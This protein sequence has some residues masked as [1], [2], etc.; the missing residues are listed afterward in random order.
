M[1]IS[2][3]NLKIDNKKLYYSITSSL[4]NINTRTISQLINKHNDIFLSV[5]FAFILDAHFGLHFLSD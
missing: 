5:L 4:D 3:V 1:Y 2:D